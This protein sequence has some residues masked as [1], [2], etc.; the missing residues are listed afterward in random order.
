MN[1]R[2]CAEETQS[3]GFIGESS[4]AGKVRTFAVMEGF[5][6]PKS[7]KCFFRCFSTEEIDFCHAKKMGQFKNDQ[8]LAQG[9][10]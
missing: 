2:G 6:F 7:S 4:F 3:A 1:E 10:I 8:M 9:E 5:G